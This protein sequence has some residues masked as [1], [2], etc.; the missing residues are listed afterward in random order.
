MYIIK[1]SAILN[2][3]F[4]FQKNHLILG[5]KYIRS[6]MLGLSFPQMWPNVSVLL[7]FY[8]SIS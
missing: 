6:L 8:F 4:F 3:W 2:F 5:D 1:E 7:N